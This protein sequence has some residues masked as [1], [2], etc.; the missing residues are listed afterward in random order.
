MACILIKSKFKLILKHFTVEIWKGNKSD[1]KKKKKNKTT[2]QIWCLQYVFSF[3]YTTTLLQIYKQLL[4]YDKHTWK[5]TPL[6]LL[7]LPLSLQMACIFINYT[8]LQI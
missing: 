8:K 7:H 3:L 6:P 5:I 1:K 2:T 4:G